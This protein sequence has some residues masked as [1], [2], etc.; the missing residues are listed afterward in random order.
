MLWPARLLALPILGSGE[1][2]TVVTGD[3]SGTYSREK[4]AFRVWNTCF[5]GDFEE[6]QAVERSCF[7]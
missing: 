4:P 1:P 2:G 7:Q 3:V 6:F 5:W